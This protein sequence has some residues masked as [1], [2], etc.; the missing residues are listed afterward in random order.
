MDTTKREISNIED[1]K[2]LVDGFYQKV[3]EDSTLGPIFN[4]RIKDRWPE[5]LDKMYRFWQ[6]VL[7]EEHTY[8]GSPF[9]PH[10]QLP[11]DKSHFDQWLKLFYETVDELY[12]GKKAVKAK[13]QG[14]RMA[15]MFHSKIEYFRNNPQYKVL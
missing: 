3:R 14:Q 5:H 2:I 13:K 1:I 4:E 11:V 10:A 7:L 8:H 12:T 15:E 6:T 9:V